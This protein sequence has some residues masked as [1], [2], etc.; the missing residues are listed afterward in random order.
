MDS[1]DHP[2]KLSSR[3]QPFRI[4]YSHANARDADR[5]A[6]KCWKTIVAIDFLANIFWSTIANGERGGPVE[7]IM[8]GSIPIGVI[9][10]SKLGP[11]LFI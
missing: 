10:I 7:G 2:K 4:D 8:Q 9:F 11:T 3:L 1:E 5:P 6:G